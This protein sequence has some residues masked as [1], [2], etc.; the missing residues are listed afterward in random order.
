MV[1]V[2]HHED[3]V[4]EIGRESQIRS[5]IEPN[6]ESPKAKIAAWPKMK[7][8]G[9]KWRPCP[10]MTPVS[11][12]LLQIWLELIGNIMHPR[13]YLNHLIC[14]SQEEPGSGLQTSLDIKNDKLQEAQESFRNLK[15]SYKEVV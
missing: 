12:Q 2:V 15:A 11:K 13:S 6:S 3:L 5:R 10:F 9:R 14:S 4:V 1:V 8:R 7:V